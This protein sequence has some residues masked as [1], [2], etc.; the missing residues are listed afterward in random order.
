MLWVI[1]SLVKPA[2]SCHPIFIYLFIF[3]FLVV[4]FHYLVKIKMRNIFLVIY[5]YFSKIIA[6]FAQKKKKKKEKKK[7]NKLIW[8]RQ[9]NLRNSASFSSEVNFLSVVT[10]WDVVSIFTPSNHMVFGNTNIKDNLFLII[11]YSQ[12]VTKPVISNNKKGETT[13]LVNEAFWFS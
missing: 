12:R 2:L 4:K 10:L 5:F 7:T 8:Y 9:Q 3:K 1:C 6:T 11:Y 13:S